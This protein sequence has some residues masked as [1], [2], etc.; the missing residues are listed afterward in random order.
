VPHCDSSCT[1]AV[2]A[3]EHHDVEPSYWIPLEELA[4]P[5]ERRDWLEH[6][7][8]KLAP[9]ELGG[10]HVLLRRLAELQHPVVAPACRPWETRAEEAE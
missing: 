5:D 7:R 4:D 3:C 10:L 9:G 1:L 2:L 6:L 8:D